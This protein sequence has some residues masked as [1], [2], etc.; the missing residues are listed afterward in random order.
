[1]LGALRMAAAGLVGGCLPAALALLGR[2]EAID[3]WLFIGL[4]GAASYV[5]LILF[6]WFLAVLAALGLIVPA[7]IVYGYAMTMA[8]I[9]QAVATQPARNAFRAVR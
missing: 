8:A 3:D 6:A 4:S 2:M 9:F 7:L 1:M 5:L